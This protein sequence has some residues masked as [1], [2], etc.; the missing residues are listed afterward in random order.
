MIRFICSEFPTF[1]H[2]RDFD[3]PSD[4]GTDYGSD[5][6]SEFVK[7]DDESDPILVQLYR[8][9]DDEIKFYVSQP[10]IPSVPDSERIF[11]DDLEAL[12]DMAAYI[13]RAHN[14]S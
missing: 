12:V 8:T 7:P 10:N 6:F 2:H 4:Y 11:A 13:S 14:G 3:E 9:A 1:A 5:Y